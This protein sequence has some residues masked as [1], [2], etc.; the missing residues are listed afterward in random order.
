ML[1]C[2]RQAQQSYTW[3][4]RGSAGG[5]SHLHESLVRRNSFGLDNQDLTRAQGS[6]HFREK[7]PAI[8]EAMDAF[9]N[10]SCKAVLFDMDGTLVDS[11]RVVELVWGWWAARH[12]VPLETVLS[13][14][15]GR[16]SIATME[17]FF[18]ARDHTEELKELE[19]YTESLLEGIVA[20][21]G[22]AQVVH[23]LQNHP[24]GI[25]TSAWRTLA[26]S[27]ITAAGLPLPRVIVPVD[28]ICKGKP[29]PEGFLHAAERLG[30]AP[31]DCLVFED[32]RP[33]VEAGL[34]AGMQVV[35]LL[36]TVP[37]EQL[38][39]RPLIR[40]FR[41]VRIQF[42]EERLKVELRDRSPIIDGTGFDC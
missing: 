35:G 19:H 39:H 17:H 12:H 11:T 25:V 20:V 33:G 2:D 13:F 8:M 26:E 29:E 37:A 27:R 1:D 38:R 32:T 7:Q 18:P 10:V 3:I 41:D 24:W 36:T 9:V 28:E 5:F 6:L 15:H 34:N 31:K 14:S 42:D 16:P 30:V 4:L 40:D 22:A 21:P 23:A